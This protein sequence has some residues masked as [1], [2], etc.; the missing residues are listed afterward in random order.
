MQNSKTKVKTHVKLKN[1]I[2]FFYRQTGE[3]FSDKDF[4]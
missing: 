3:S 1:N 4:A 2:G